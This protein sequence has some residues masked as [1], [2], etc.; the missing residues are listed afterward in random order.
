V[1]WYC[2]ADFA[3]NRDVGYASSILQ[4]LSKAY[5]RSPLADGLQAVYDGVIKALRDSKDQPEEKYRLLHASVDILGRS[6]Q[7]GTSLKLTR[8]VEIH[9]LV[10]D[11]L[12]SNVK[13]CRKVVRQFLAEFT[14]CK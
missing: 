9:P 10:S 12:E 2:I 5:I 4:I 8:S 11:L 13:K 3:P 7:A 14:D 1:P 6:A